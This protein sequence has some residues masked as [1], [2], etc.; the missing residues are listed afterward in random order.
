MFME[1]LGYGTHLV[2][3]GFAADG[4]TLLDTAVLQSFLLEQA[5]LL[6]PGKRAVPEVHTVEVLPTGLSAALLLPESHLSLHT[7][8]ESRIIT[9][10]VFSRHG[11]ALGSLTDSLAATFR[12]RRFESHLSNHSRT[13]SK[14]D[15]R[16][17][18]TLHGERSYAATRLT[19][20]FV[21]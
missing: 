10:S 20:A 13:M 11:L 2:I 4:A 14:E 3:D 7:F 1:T 9:L 8:V 5:D 21:F 16:R 6:E 12:V 18:R 17:T 19:G 15:L